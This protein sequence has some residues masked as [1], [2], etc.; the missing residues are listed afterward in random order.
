MKKVVGFFLLTCLVWSAL[1]I[2]HDFLESI[3]KSK[4]KSVTISGFELIGCE[5][6]FTEN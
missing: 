5:F 4:M 1:K 2:E 3:K 6:V